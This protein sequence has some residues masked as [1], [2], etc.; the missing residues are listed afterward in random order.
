MT[1]FH[2][3][4]RQ[5]AHRLL[6]AVFVVAAAGSAL[7]SCTSAPPDPSARVATD[8]AIAER[9]LANGNEQKAYRQLVVAAQERGRWLPPAERLDLAEALLEIRDY[10]WAGNLTLQLFDESSLGPRAD[11]SPPPEERHRSLLL[12]GKVLFFLSRA[13]LESPEPPEEAAQRQASL[14]WAESALRQV[15]DAQGPRSGEA[16]Y[17]LAKVLAVLEKGSEAKALQDRFLKT[18]P[19]EKRRDTMASLPTCGTWSKPPASE[20]LVSTKLEGLTPPVKEHA[21]P[22]KYTQPARFAR[23]QGSVI[24]QAII[25]SSGKPVCFHVLKALP[26]GLTEAAIE[27]IS[28]WRFVPAKLGGQP[29][30]VFYN[31]S[32]NFK[33][34]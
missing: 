15:A 28:R 4:S 8:L 32:V 22:P 1:P 21:P 19:E 27:T 30:S 18:V 3:V 11:W 23:I 20:P 26:Q 6:Q 29:V 13:P 5:S 17:Y 10:R 31:L 25:D 7:A 34:Q 24:V 33:L 14:E 12:L 2:R 9:A 16:L